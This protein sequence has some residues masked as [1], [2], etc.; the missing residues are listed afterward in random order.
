MKITIVYPHLINTGSNIE[1]IEG[2]SNFQE[3]SYGIYFNIKED[4]MF[5]GYNNIIG[6]F[7]K[8]EDKNDT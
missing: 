6:F 5:I 4:Y 3:K 8:E 7:L 1:T 2:I